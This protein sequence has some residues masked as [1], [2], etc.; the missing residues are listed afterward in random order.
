MLVHLTATNGRPILL[1]TTNIV[2]VRPYSEAI[3]LIETTA[4]RGSSRTIAVRGSL[5]E[6]ARALSRRTPSTELRAGRRRRPTRPIFVVH[7]GG[8]Q[9]ASARPE[10]DE[11]PSGP[12]V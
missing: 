9:S 12:G 7:E 6:I 5:Y 3:S 1:E 10:D 2:A 8:R 11:S 4:A